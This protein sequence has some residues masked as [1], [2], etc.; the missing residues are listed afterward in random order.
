MNRNYYIFKSGTL[1][2]KDNSIR[3]VTEDKIKKDIPCET[4]SDLYVFGEI[5]LNT[6]LLNFLAQKE[7]L[8]HVFNCVYV[9]NLYV[10]LCIYNTHI[11]FKAR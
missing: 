3:V 11:A 4:V 6:Q 8:L 2:R 5:N 9:C 1:Q 7:I 10:A